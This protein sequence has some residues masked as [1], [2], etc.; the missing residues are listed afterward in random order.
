VN[1]GYSVRSGPWALLPTTGRQELYTHF[2]RIM[3]G[4]ELQGHFWHDL[5]S[6]PPLNVLNHH[7]L[8][9]FLHSMKGF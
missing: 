6:I 1:C 2:C 5:S 9:P 7:Q 8:E 3:L 4:W